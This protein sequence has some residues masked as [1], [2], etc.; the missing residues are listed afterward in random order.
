MIKVEILKMYIRTDVG[1]GAAS[2]CIDMQEIYSNGVGLSE[3]FEEGHPFNCFI[4]P[5]LEVNFTQSK[6]RNMSKC[7]EIRLYVRKRA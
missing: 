5:Y 1:F 3:T 4:V 2:S 6:V 7:P